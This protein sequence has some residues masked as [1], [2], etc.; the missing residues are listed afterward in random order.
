MGRS[1]GKPLL[2][3]DAATAAEQCAARLVD[4]APLTVRFIRAQMR[5][6]MPEL[7][8]SQFR[9]MAF[10]YR[11]RGCALREVAAHLGVTPATC[12]SLV[13]RLVERGLATRRPNM[14]N[15]RQVILAL[16]RGGVAQVEAA[17]DAA[18]RHTA[19][20][21]AA[22]PERTLRGLARSLDAL[23]DV[24]SETPEHTR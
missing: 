1:A 11:R 22:L 9:A 13:G 3:D 23:A 24:F 7:T 18:R 21:L 2:R 15:R 14:A 10:L 4:V 17:R 20:M 5:R 19:R 6:Q 16:T 8:M 12:S